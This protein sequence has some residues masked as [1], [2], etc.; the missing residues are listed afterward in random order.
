MS[1]EETEADEL[2]EDE[3][4][5]L[6]QAMKDVPTPDEKHNVHTFLQKVV[7]E[8]DS[9]KIGNLLDDKN[10][11]ELGEPSHTVRG[12]FELARISE[13]LMDN[14]FF[15]DWFLFEAENILATS[16]SREGFLIRQATTTTKQVA[17]ATRRVKTNKSW[18]K[19]KEEKT[20][21]DITRT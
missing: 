7:M 20:G 4:L 15:R 12:S 10:F 9:R 14:P 2:T 11:S 13:L 19:S 5:K 3:L 6:A 16:L 21:G 1:E 8:E 18:F 17:D